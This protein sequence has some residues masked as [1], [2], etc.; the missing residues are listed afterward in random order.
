MIFVI[1]AG[2]PDNYRISTS[3]SITNIIN[4]LAETANIQWFCTLEENVSGVIDT[5]TY[6]PCVGVI[7]IHAMILREMPALD[8]ISNF[9]ISQEGEGVD[10]LQNKTNVFPDAIGAY[11]RI[12]DIHNLEQS[13]LGLDLVV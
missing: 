2:I 5:Y 4:D 11:D 13:S 8:T 12:D 6:N 10:I 9:G 7:K 3:S 1:E